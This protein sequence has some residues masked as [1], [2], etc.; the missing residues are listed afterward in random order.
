MADTKTATI[1]DLY[2]VGGEK[3]ELVD[4]RIARHVAHRIFTWLT[5]LPK[6]HV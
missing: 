1:D 2:D 3:A 5:L 4:G 6:V